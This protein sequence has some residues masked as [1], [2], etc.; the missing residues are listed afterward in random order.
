M[1]FFADES[2]LWSWCNIQ[3]PKVEVL[4][5]NF[6]TKNY[7][8]PDFVEKTNELKVLI[9]SNYGFFHA[10]IKNFQLLWSL[11]NLKRIRLEKISISSLCETLVPLK[12]LRKIS[13]FMCNIGKAFENCTNKVSYAL[14]NLEEINIDYCNDLVELPVGLCDIVHLKK[15]CITNCHKLA[16]LPKGTRKLVNLEN[17]RLRSC[18]DLLEL[19]ESIRSLHKLSI[20][21][22]SDCLSISKLPKHIGELCNLKVL[23]MKG[24][25]K[26]HNPLPESTMDL[27]QLKIVVCDKETAKLWEPIKE[28]LTKLKIEVAKN[29]INLNWLLK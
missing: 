4:I 5:L 17:L 26:L 7:T 1:F 15:L 12:S 8:L 28:F 13:L 24:C 18:T 21:D 25:L 11:P 6:Q 20:L 10:E 16:I 19:P 29:D 27:K 14:P 22:I 9:V 3:A 2:F 23:N